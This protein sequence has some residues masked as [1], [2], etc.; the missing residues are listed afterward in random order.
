MVGRNSC[1][2]GH[3]D[4]VLRRGDDKQ[5]VQTYHNAL[6]RA[7]ID[8]GDENLQSKHTHDDDAQSN[9]RQHHEGNL[10][11]L[12]QQLLPSWEV[13][14]RVSR[15]LIDNH[16]L[17]AELRPVGFHGA[18]VAHVP[19]DAE[20]QLEQFPVFEED[21]APDT[22]DDAVG[23]GVFALEEPGDG[24]GEG[25][26][27]EEDEI[28]LDEGEVKCDLFFLM[29]LAFF[30]TTILARHLGQVSRTYLGPKQ[31]AN[32]IEIM[33][34]QDEPSTEVS[35]QDL[36]GGLIVQG[37]DGLHILPLTELGRDAGAAEGL[38][39]V[40]EVVHGE[41]VFCLVGALDDG[42]F[43]AA[44]VGGDDAEEP[45]LDPFWGERR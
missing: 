28:C 21:G 17:P 27:E 26:E 14:L 25:G 34:G 36:V 10:Q 20:V 3:Q 5:Q 39:P 33:I 42:G 2:N 15:G 32:L 13:I 44:R 19:P 24:A 12:P 41:D 7:S 6:I 4:G 37:K 38:G 9:S 35:Q 30:L 29:L 1:Q 16:A 18:D 8:L 31:I 22:G 45:V 23:E 43:G 11:Q 40:D